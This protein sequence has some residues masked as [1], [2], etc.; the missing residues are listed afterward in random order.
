MI[1]VLILEADK[2]VVLV[3]SVCLLVDEDKRLVQAF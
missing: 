2:T 1:V 3:S